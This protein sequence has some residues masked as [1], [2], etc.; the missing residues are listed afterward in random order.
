MVPGAAAA[1]SGNLLET[2]ILGSHP[3]TTEVEIVSLGP[4]L[5]CLPGDSEIQLKFE[6]HSSTERISQ[7]SSVVWKDLVW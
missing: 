1:S 7:I 2:Q 4:I 3:G 6:N 5:T